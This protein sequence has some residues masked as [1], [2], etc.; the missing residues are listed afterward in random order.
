M[1]SEKTLEARLL[2]RVNVWSMD[3]NYYCCIYVVHVAPVMLCAYDVVYILF[4]Q[5][6]VQMV[7]FT[8]CLCSV[9]Y[10]WC[11]P[12]VGYVVLC[13]YGVVRMLEMWCCVHMV[14]CTY[15][16]VCMVVQVVL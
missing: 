14:L 2:G 5:C 4:M 13:A 10:R 3:V 16:V 11:C 8:C 6:Y 9:V 7:L 12:H 1:N 15:G